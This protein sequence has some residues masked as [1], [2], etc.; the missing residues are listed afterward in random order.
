MVLVCN[1]KSVTEAWKRAKAFEGPSFLLLSC[2]LHLAFVCFSDLLETKDWGNKI[3][4]KKKKWRKKQN[5]TLHPFKG[6]K[7]YKKVFE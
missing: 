3:K 2:A 6:V 4:N 1:L 7:K 5:Q